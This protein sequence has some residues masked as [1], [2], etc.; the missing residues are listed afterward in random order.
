MQEPS[1]AVKLL[2]HAIGD[3]PGVVIGDRADDQAQIRCFGL[4][5]GD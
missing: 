2:D 1:V 3:L 5:F 4:Q